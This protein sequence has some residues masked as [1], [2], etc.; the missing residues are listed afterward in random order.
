MHDE[1]RGSWVGLTQTLI[2]QSMIAHHIIL[3]SI[4]I[5]EG[6]LFAYSVKPGQQANRVL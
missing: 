1:P 2:A 3:P 5:C 4:A 6:L